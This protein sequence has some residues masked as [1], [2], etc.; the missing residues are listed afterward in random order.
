[1]EWS[2]INHRILGRNR[3]PAAASVASEEDALRMIGKTNEAARFREIVAETRERL[4]PLLR[5]AC[6]QTLRRARLRA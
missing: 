4:P 3:V 6:P 5:V 2:E 1:M